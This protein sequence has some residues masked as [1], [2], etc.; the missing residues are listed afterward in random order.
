MLEAKLKAR[1]RGLLR[2]TAKCLVKCFFR[3]FFF[4][5]GGVFIAHCFFF[6]LGGGDFLYF[7]NVFLFEGGVL[8]FRG[9]L[10]FFDL[11]GCQCWASGLLQ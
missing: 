7:L 5:G 4:L 6:F 2:W 9:L 1:Q 3:F 11:V 8:G 10:I